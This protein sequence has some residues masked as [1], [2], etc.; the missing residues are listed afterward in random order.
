MLDGARFKCLAISRSE[1]PAFSP[2]EISSRSLIDKTR[3]ERQR[4]RGAIPPLAYTTFDTKFGQRCR[5]SAISVTDSPAFQRRHNSTPCSG[6]S[7]LLGL[8][9]HPPSRSDWNDV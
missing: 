2:R 7:R 1:H 4:S 5:A 8:A 6:D 3:A 9:I